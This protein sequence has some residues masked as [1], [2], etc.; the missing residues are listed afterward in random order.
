MEKRINLIVCIDKCTKMLQGVASEIKECESKLESPKDDG[1]A[2]L[3]DSVLSFLDRELSGNPFSRCD[4][5]EAV[6]AEPKP[7]VLLLPV[8]QAVL[9]L[10]SVDWF[11]AFPWAT[12]RMIIIGAM[13]CNGMNEIWLRAGGKCKP[14]PVPQPKYPRRCT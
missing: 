3:Y 4:G 13:I 9:R 5:A 7:V 1:T 2:Q 8:L 12:R 6:V 11:H 10:A 14:L